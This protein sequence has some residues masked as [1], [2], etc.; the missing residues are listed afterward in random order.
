MSN[1]NG[2]KSDANNCSMSGVRRKSSSAGVAS[3]EANTLRIFTPLGPSAVWTW[4]SPTATSARY[5]AIGAVSSYVKVVWVP[6][7]L[8]A[9]ATRSPLATA[10]TPLGTV[11]WNVYVALSI[12]WSFTG[13]HV[14]APSGSLRTKLLSPV[15]I[16]P[17]AI[18][19]AL[20]DRGSGEPRYSTL[21]VKSLPFSSG[22]AGVM[23]SSPPSRVKGASLP[24]TLRVYTSSPSRSRL[25]RERSC[26][27]VAEMVATASILL[28]AGSTE[29]FSA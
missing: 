2:P 6:S 7:A 21:T 22:F 25:N 15:L 10:V 11:R 3:G 26:V 14:D 16:Q 9:C 27:A 24:S 28:M 18:G 8:G 23:T 12:G 20:V 19:M 5:D 29:R 13:N 17:T 1:G 4:K